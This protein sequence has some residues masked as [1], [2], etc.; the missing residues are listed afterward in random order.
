MSQGYAVD[1]LEALY[2]VFTLKELPPVAP[3]MDEDSYAPAITSGGRGAGDTLIP[4]SKPLT[5]QIAAGP[6]VHFGTI[7]TGEVESAAA[8]RQRIAAGGN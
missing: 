4:G 7:R 8:A 3:L 5:K 2:T 1:L 6:A